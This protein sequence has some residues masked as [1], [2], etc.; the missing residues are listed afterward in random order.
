[1]WVSLVVES[2]AYS[3]CSAGASNCG[4]LLL[5]SV[6]SVNC[7]LWAL[8]RRLRS[9]GAQ[10]YLPL[11]K[12]SLP[13]RDHTCVPCIGR[14]ILNHWTTRTSNTRSILFYIFNQ[15]SYSVYCVPGNDVKYISSFGCFTAWEY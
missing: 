9:W 13:D 3:S 15:N 12:G 5:Q 2:G 14:R 11:G 4:S 10:S 7:V 1:M 8:E 6:G